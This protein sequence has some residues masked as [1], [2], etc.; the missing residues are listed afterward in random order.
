M[1]AFRSHWGASVCSSHCGDLYLALKLFTQTL[2]SGSHVTLSCNSCFVEVFFGTSSMIGFSL[3]VFPMFSFKFS[4]L[5]SWVIHLLE[6]YF[7]HEQSY[8]IDPSFEASTRHDPKL[9]ILKKSFLAANIIFPHL[10]DYVKS[11]LCSGIF[12]KHH[13]NIKH[14]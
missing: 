5:T 11:T 6:S 9:R 8:F 3:G 7:L 4:H 2:T 13:I 14:S 1:S 12:F 10:W